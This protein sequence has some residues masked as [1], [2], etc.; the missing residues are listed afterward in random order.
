VLTTSPLTSSLAYV[1]LDTFFSRLILTFNHSQTEG[2]AKIHPVGAISPDEEKLIKEC[3]PE[4]KKNIEK[5]VKFV[6]GA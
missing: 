2:I 5:G 4:L 3:L 6:E 1:F